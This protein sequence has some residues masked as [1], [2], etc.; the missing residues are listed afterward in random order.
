MFERDLRKYFEGKI[1]ATELKAVIDKMLK[2]EDFDSRDDS[3]GTEM[4]LNAHHLVKVCDDILA[5]KMSPDYAAHIGAELTTSDQF[6]FE[7]SALGSRAEDVAFDWD[8]YDVTYLFNLETIQKFKTRLLTGND[9][10]VDSDF[11]DSE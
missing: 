8:S 4:E 1:N 11:A 10:F 5:G 2:D 7:D 6:I 3:F 9:L